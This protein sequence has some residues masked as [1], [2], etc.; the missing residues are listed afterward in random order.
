MSF[1]RKQLSLRLSGMLT[2][3]LSELNMKFMLSNFVDIRS[4]LYAL[5]K[6]GF[7]SETNN[8]NII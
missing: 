2:S 8:N 3:L 4:K 6:D 5:S 1:S 7:F